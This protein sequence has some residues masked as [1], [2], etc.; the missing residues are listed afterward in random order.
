[1]KITEAMLDQVHKLQQKRLA[2][3]E[4]N[5][6]SVTLLPEQ[7]QIKTV[8]SG[9]VWYFS[10]GTQLAPGQRLSHP[11]D[12]QFVALSVEQQAGRIAV[13]VEPLMDVCCFFSARSTGVDPHGRVLYRLDGTGWNGIPCQFVSFRVILP[14]AFTPTKGDV[15]S[16]D[17][18]YWRVVSIQRTN[19]VAIA[20]VEEF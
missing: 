8:R 15:L 10:E 9:D 3:I 11:E 19:A 5:G 14:K 6:E 18:N 7:R 12:G 16:I 13:V 20:T 4:E 1:M 2:E 17:G